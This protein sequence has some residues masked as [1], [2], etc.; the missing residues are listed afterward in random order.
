M[1][2]KYPFMDGSEFE[3]NIS[4]GITPIHHIGKASKIGKSE[5]RTNNNNVSKVRKKTKHHNNCER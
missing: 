2:E 1:K 4:F 3:K 5:A